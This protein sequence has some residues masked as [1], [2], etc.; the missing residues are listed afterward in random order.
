VGG[1]MSQYVHGHDDTDDDVVHSD[2][3]LT[4]RRVVHPARD[5]RS[6]TTMAVRLLHY[7]TFNF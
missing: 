1:W 7:T 5:T 3:E 2:T 4:H 6:S